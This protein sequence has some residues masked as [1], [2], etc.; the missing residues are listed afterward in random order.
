MN[1]SR[2]R[3]PRRAALLLALGGLSAALGTA[4]QAAGNGSR[5]VATG[6]ASAFEGAAGGGLVPWALL[7]GY[8]DHGEVG[9][10]AFASTVRVDDFSLAVA[11][12]SVSI[13]NRV[14]LSVAKQRFDIDSII[15][16]ETL[17]QTVLGIKFRL[18]GEV[19]YDRGAQVSLGLQLKQSDTFDVPEAV[20]ARN[21]SGV[22]VYVAASKLWLAGPFGRSMFVNGT[23][24]ATQ[25]N[26]SGLMGFGTAGDSGHEL[27]AEAAAGVFLNRHWVIGAEYRQKPDRLA[28]AR[29]D[30]WKDVFVGWF[31]NK[32]LSLVAA[33]TDLGSIAGLDE[34]RGVYL[35]VEIAR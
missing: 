20:G 34:Q 28:F 19:P 6:G 17:E 11:G 26:Q 25:A 15:P 27:M 13:D 31:P 35:S 16:D 12:A 21:D 30:D 29:E 24:R 32:R 5:I 33:Y 10:A 9:A 8:G 18:F 7:S 22:D 2:T 4:V 3:A 1:R 14:E 23:L